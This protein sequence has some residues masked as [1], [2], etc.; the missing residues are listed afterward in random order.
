MDV[1]LIS[2]FLGAG[3]TTFLKRLLE[4]KIDRIGKLAVIVNEIGEVGIDGTLLAGQHV[5]MVELTSGCIC[6]TMK[7]DFQRAVGEIHDRIDPNVLMVETTGVAQ[8]A[9]LLD[10]L[11]FP[12]LR[13]FTLL[14]CLVTVIDANFFKA[15]KLLGAF[16]DNQIRFADTLILNKI[17][18]VRPS[19]L[20]TVKKQLQHLN[21]NARLLTARHCN[22][23]LGEFF[24]GYPADR[25]EFLR[26]KEAGHHHLDWGFDSFCFTET[27]PLNKRKFIAFIE[28]L[29][30]NLFR[31]KGWVRFSDESS[32]F[33]YTGGRYRFES[34]DGLRD[35]TLT[36]VGRN[37]RK[38]EL[39]YA[40]RS[41]LE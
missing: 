10:V 36:F 35:T 21:P 34:L 19:F 8:P 3:K 6:C 7:T 26:E 5:D 25:K 22:V 28:S 16:Y 30:S 11:F 31:I 13:E 33:D 15:R 37:W 38:T 17:D 18:L 2:G 40:L 23:D 41:C 1:L 12:P 29:P 24:Q 9:E 4:S 32:F 20:N 27:T 14:R 39:L